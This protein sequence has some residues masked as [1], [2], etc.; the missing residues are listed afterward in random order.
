MR[1]P[2]PPRPASM[3]QIGQAGAVLIFLPPALLEE[4]LPETARHLADLWALLQQRPPKEAG[5]GPIAKLAVM[6]PMDRDADLRQALTV[7]GRTVRRRHRHHH[8]QCRISITGEL[9]ESVFPCCL[10]GCAGAR[11]S[12]RPGR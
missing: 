3:P 4:R 11:D 7:L 6:V 2:A 8:R 9:I 10:C 1:V 12:P 5:A